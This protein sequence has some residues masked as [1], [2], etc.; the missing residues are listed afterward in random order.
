M[1]ILKK[2]PL[3]VKNGLRDSTVSI[4]RQCPTSAI[5]FEWLTSI[6]TLI[7]AAHFHIL[8]SCSHN[9]W[10]TKI[11]LKPVEV[12]LMM[13]DLDFSSIIRTFKNYYFWRF[14]NKRMISKLIRYFSLTPT[15]IVQFWPQTTICMP[16]SS[17]FKMIL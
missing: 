14:H 2:I 3:S 12:I 11:S 10:S 6:W 16:C 1:T 5:Y 17:Q 15:K 13:P 7:T 9:G 4:G 8:I